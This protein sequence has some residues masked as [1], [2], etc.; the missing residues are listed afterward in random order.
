MRFTV[1][2]TSD[3]MK[4]MITPSDGETPGIAFSEAI[5]PAA[6]VMKERIRSTFAMPPLSHENPAPRYLYTTYKPY[7]P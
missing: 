2:L 5:N 4:K 6:F 3:A 7:S 1:S